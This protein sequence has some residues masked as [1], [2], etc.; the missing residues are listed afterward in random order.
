MLKNA[1]GSPLT[2]SFLSLEKAI[3]LIHFDQTVPGYKCLVMKEEKGEDTNVG[4][5][6]RSLPSTSSKALSPSKLAHSPGQ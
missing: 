6:W 5:L 3:F 1:W 4:K 2:L